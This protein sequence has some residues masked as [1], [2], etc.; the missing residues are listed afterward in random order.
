MP[1]I[2]HA[3]DLHLDSPFDGL[4]AGAA[5]LRRAEQRAM[6]DRVA[7]LVREERVELVLLAGDLLDSVSSYFETQETLARAFESMPC[8]IF[9]APGN[10]DY[11][12]AKS[13]YAYV[14]FPPN[15]HIFTSPTIECV[16][17]PSLNTRVWGAGFTA[18]SAEPILRGFRARGGGTN[19][20][21]LHGD[22]RGAVYNNVT[23]VEIASSGLDYLALGHVHA[24]SGILRAGGTHYAYPGCPEGRGFDETGK[25]GVIIGDITDSA[26]DL[27]FVPLGGREY[28]IAE[29][30]LTGSADALSAIGGATTA[31][32]SRD[33]A[34]VV[35]TGEFDGRVNVP[36]LEKQLA[37][38]FFQ[39]SVRD[40]T[41]PRRDLWDGADE[42]TL[43]GA[44]LREMRKKFDEIIETDGEAR[45]RV[46]LATR[47][48]LAALDNGEEC[49]V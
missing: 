20:M 4:S 39:V 15:V 32:S 3:A 49:A 30:D 38:R 6:L 41:H 16:E 1:R 21:V 24:Y 2:L 42:D 31:V 18:A 25:K 43:R 44:F 19:L 37:N 22:T 10:H 28:V 17:L 12:C 29:V 47:Y 46:T 40:A 23:E 34:R 45:R 33:I 13:P 8:E 36:E 9:I 5:S 26:C 35:L 14:K 27:R 11:Y 48:G 7:E